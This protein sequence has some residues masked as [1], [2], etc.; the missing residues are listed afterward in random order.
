MKAYGKS[1]TGALR[2]GIILITSFYS[3]MVIAST[4]TWI[5]HFGKA[6]GRDFWAVG[7]GVT[8]PETVAETEDNFFIAYFLPA[9]LGVHAVVV[10][11]IV[12]PSNVVVRTAQRRMPETR[13][14]IS[15]ANAFL[16]SL[17]PMNMPL[18]TSLM[19]PVSALFDTTCEVTFVREPLVLQICPATADQMVLA[20]RVTSKLSLL[21]SHNTNGQATNLPHE[22]IPWTQE[23]LVACWRDVILK[24]MVTKG[25]ASNIRY[26]ESFNCVAVDI[27]KEID[28]TQFAA[29][30][31][32]Y[33]RYRAEPD[34][35]GPGEGKK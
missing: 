20:Q 29:V 8:L 2:F 6:C 3:H 7:R 23:Q 26:Y 18:S 16:L 11:N 33:S 28:F 35:S 34:A 4:N 31:S 32:G 19:L 9:A 5:I 24:E 13:D 21:A 15:Y 17:A 1:R 30:M 27:P 12:I 25:W 22:N 10:T 14:S